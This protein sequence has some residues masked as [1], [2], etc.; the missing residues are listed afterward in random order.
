M[1]VPAWVVWLGGVGVT[2]I[3]A[4]ARIFAPVRDRLVARR[5]TRALG[6]LLS[7]SM[8]VGFWI[9]AGLGW[10]GG[11]R[12]PVDLVLTGGALSVLSYAADMALR[13]LGSGFD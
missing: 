2:L 8:C 12:A 10:I 6:K 11:N 7:C 4:T 9:G 3:V 1:S 5:T 13:R